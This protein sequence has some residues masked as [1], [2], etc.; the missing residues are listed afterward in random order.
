M[1]KIKELFIDRISLKN[2]N[3]EVQKRVDYLVN[4]NI[5]LFAF[6]IITWGGVGL[7]AKVYEGLLF[8][9]SWNILL[10]ISLLVIRKN[11]FIL[12]SYLTF[13]TVYINIITASILLPFDSYLAVY[14][15]LSF[16]LALLIV[17]T[18]LSFKR[19][20]I[21]SVAIIGIISLNFLA[22]YLYLPE[23]GGFTPL[24]TSAY[25]TMNV[26]MI[27][28]SIIATYTLSFS[29][30]LIHLAQ[31]KQNYITNIIDSMPSVIISIDKDAKITEWNKQAET[32][33]G[34]PF[35]RALG[36]LITDAYPHISS[37]MKKIK[38]SIEK[39][40]IKI[41]KNRK[42]LIDD[43][44][45][46]EDI[47][48]YPLMEHK[49][50]GAVIRIDDVTEE[51]LLK[52]QLNQSRKM[53]AIGQLAGGIAHDF[54]NM[55]SGIMGGAQLLNL[56][57][58]L[59]NDAQE[60]IEMI[61]QSAERASSLSSKLLAFSRKNPLDLN[62]I[63]I[64]R[65]ISD[66]ITILKSTIDK[67]IQIEFENNAK[68]TIFAGDSSQINNAL[69]NMGINSAHAM[70]NGGKLS[71]TTNNIEL[72]ENYCRFSPFDLEPGNFIEIEIRDTGCGIPLE[73]IDK[74]FEPFYT[75][76]PQGQG[77]GLGL[78]AVYGII[79]EHKG[80]IKVYSELGNGTVFHI[81][82]PLSDI[83]SIKKENKRIQK[84]EGTILLADDEEFIRT[85]SKKLL[86]SIGYNIILAKNGQE[87]VDIYIENQKKINIVILDMIMPVMNGREA[88]YKIK[89][90]DSSAKIIIASGFSKD[91][92]LSELSKKGLDGFIKKPYK[93]EEIS[94]I[95][96]DILQK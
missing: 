80:A 28:A 92:D 66:T 82:L 65:I 76:K 37:E 18:I 36:R 23:I 19:V 85:I 33:T 87:A 12:A 17:S 6:F 53:D 75:T 10:I 29:H 25:I 71:F 26:I 77:T 16:M 90:A 64:N 48:I 1:I 58:S 84:G 57:T 21:I 60:Y 40:Q 27:I 67:K 83:V 4:T 49:S 43:K 9:Y 54:N 32:V 42:I 73:N 70:P 7:G 11:K 72:D 62:P 51:F 14:R 8:G 20:Q 69:L 39:K 81:Y 63:D 89:E 59:S 94:S 93:I 35:E 52:E 79:Q 38:E 55:L 45:R 61:M 13:I 41:E 24:F 47:T 95:L 46:Y 30:D 15:P 78:S 31:E 68:Y 56:E 2:F 3:L 88:F 86:E 34:I 44:N 50:K 22:Y 5:A 74:I 96:K 91:E